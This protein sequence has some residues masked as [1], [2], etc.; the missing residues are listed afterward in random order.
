MATILKESVAIVGVNNN[1]IG[2][3]SNDDLLQ[4]MKNTGK[5]LRKIL[6]ITSDDIQKALRES[7][8]EW[9]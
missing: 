2:D 3:V 8:E 1:S 7:R 5:H 4:N 9:K 6:N